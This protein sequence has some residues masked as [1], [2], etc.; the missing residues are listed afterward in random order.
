MVMSRVRMHGSG[1]CSF[2]QASNPSP[3]CQI[4][5]LD[6]ASGTAS[7][8]FVAASHV[9]VCVTDLGEPAAVAQSVVL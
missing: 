2:E 7:M 3:D 5:I 1:P 8:G 6:Q 9:H 4:N